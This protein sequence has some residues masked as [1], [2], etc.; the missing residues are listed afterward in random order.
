MTLSSNLWYVRWFFWCC[1]VL[2]RFVSLSDRKFFMDSREEVHKNGTNLCHFFRTLFFGTLITAF[3]VS[4]YVTILFI[5]FILPFFLFNAYSIM[6]VIGII[7]GVLIGIGL[8]IASIFWLARLF[9][10]GMKY[11]GE[12][13]ATSPTKQPG[14]FAI[15]IAYLV[16]LKERYCPLMQFKDDANV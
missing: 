9:S 12:R 11:L 3:V 7:T 2:D 10:A 4:L 5:V 14:F 13:R 1:R 16:A 8:V 15:F 6:A